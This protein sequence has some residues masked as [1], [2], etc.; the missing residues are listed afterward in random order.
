MLPDQIVGFQSWEWSITFGEHKYDLFQYVYV[1]YDWTPEPTWLTH[2]GG[3][4][5]KWNLVF[6]VKERFVIL[7][8]SQE[9]LNA[10]ID[11][12]VDLWGLELRVIDKPE[13]CVLYGIMDSGG[14]FW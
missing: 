11:V 13:G 9:W 10:Y 12:E 6:D 3:M 8:Y 4:L 14:I 5:F 2:L 7:S 1:E